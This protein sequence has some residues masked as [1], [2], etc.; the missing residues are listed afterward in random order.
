MQAQYDHL[1]IS[2]DPGITVGQMVIPDSKE[3]EKLKTHLFYYNIIAEMWTE[4]AM[5]AGVFKYTNEDAQ[6]IK[7]DGEHR[8]MFI[9]TNPR[10]D[11]LMAVCEEILGKDKFDLVLQTPKSGNRYYIEWVKDQTVL[12]GNAEEPLD[13]SLDIMVH[14]EDVQDTINSQD[15]SKFKQ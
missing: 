3:I 14:Q 11:E 12:P 5:Q 8:V 13:E 6:M 2:G 10:V 4:K 15:K 9:T 7:S 1:W